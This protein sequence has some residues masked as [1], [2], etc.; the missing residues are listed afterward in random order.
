MRSWALKYNFATGLLLIVFATGLVVIAAVHVSAQP[1]RYDLIESGEVNGLYRTG[2]DESGRKLPQN[3]DDPHWIIDRV[4][5][6]AG[7]IGQ[8]CQYAHRG[9]ST[10]VPIPSTSSAQPI[11]ARTI[12]ERGNQ[13]GLYTSRDRTV[14]SG[15]SP[16]VEMV[17]GTMPWKFN[18]SNARWIGQNYYG[19]NSTQNTCRD[20][21]ESAAANMSNAN[22][23]VFK[24]KD[25]FTFNDDVDVS[26]VQ[27][28]LSA[29]V[30]NTIK[31]VVNGTTVPA[32]LTPSWSGAYR[33]VNEPGF[34]SNSPNVE[35]RPVENIFRPN[36]QRNELEL[37]VQSTYSHTG[38]LIK[39][40]E[41]LAAVPERSDYSIDPSVEVSKTVVEPEEQVAASPKLTN[42]GTTPSA[43]VSWQL[44]RFVIAPG[45]PI[46]SAAVENAT[47]PVAHFG[48]DA[49]IAGQGSTVV[50]VGAQQQSDSQSQV[51]EL[52]AGTKICYATS[53]R[54]FS[55][56][57]PATSWRHG[58]PACAVVG[59]KP[60]VQVHGGDLKVGG[61]IRGA[62]SIPDLSS[63]VS[64]T[65]TVRGGK[66]YG[67]WVEYGITATGSVVNT[68][69]ASG[70]AGG[71]SETNQSDWSRL[72]F[73]NTP[74]FGQFGVAQ[75]PI[76]DISGSVVRPSDIA[77]APRISGTVQIT[78][79]TRGLRV[80]NSDVTLSGY[81]FA[82]PGQSVIIY[83]PN[84]VVTIADN[85][86]YGVTTLRST[87]DIPQLIIIADTIRIQS[88]VTQLDAWVI[89]SG[90]TGIVDTCADVARLSTSVCDRALTVNGPVVSKKL[91]LK[92]TA[93]SDDP[94]DTGRSSAAE[95]F[96]LRPDAYLWAYS[97][98]NSED[99]VL[100]T[101]TSELPPRF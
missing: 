88:N 66:A 37:H 99:R 15:Y 56:A 33:D 31:I 70:L 51:E 59:K 21:T 26:S 10:I 50:E 84:S 38:V 69:S 43:N 40:V 62:S 5:R 2:V 72:T 34:A 4:Y 73:A 45:R 1:A 28:K 39:D 63:I 18:V 85:V 42:R 81:T 98:S 90:D 27:L 101:H 86:T 77:A 24:L 79:A 53:V 60:L 19:Q 58:Q 44:T 57:S 8:P 36:G 97:Y 54:P 92:R 64:T 41:A 16:L 46:P 100:T 20:P 95:T 65:N 11:P 80:A 48:N 47:T 71:S 23:Y 14:T 75:R 82:A 29:A 74:E 30:D 76:P 83:A 17:N 3:V 55:A 7:R 89:A 32:R 91:L 25:G 13:T 6:P 67:S 87:E 35:T 78:P 9:G 94:S 93:G 52:P 22:I 96:N 68:A 49:T 12:L 61:V